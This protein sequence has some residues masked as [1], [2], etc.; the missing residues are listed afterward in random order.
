MTGDW[1]P[2]VSSNSDTLWRN[3]TIASESQWE[4]VVV[5]TVET[6]YIN[7]KGIAWSRQ[8]WHDKSNTLYRRKTRTPDKNYF[9]TNKSLHHYLDRQYK[10]YVVYSNA[11]QNVHEKNAVDLKDTNA[12]K[13][14]GK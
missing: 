10:K 7:H 5:V 14:K 3:E 11:L 13:K 4:A 6:I 8:S 2:L 1:E 9:H 12:A